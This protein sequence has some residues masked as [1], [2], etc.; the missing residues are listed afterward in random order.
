M[1]KDSKSKLRSRYRSK[2]SNHSSNQKYSSRA[3]SKEILHHSALNKQKNTLNELAKYRKIRRNKD[4]SYQ[5]YGE[6]SKIRRLRNRNSSKLRNG[7]Y[8]TASHNSHYL[9]NGSVDK[10]RKMEMS[11]RVERSTNKFKEIGSCY[12]PDVELG[13]MRFKSKKRYLL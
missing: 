11:M 2:D 1:R 13:E 4:P 6:Q 12:L 8:N 7:Y 5:R 10:K 9:R 3:R